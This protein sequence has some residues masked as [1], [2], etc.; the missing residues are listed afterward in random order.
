M[1]PKIRFLIFHRRGGRR[2]ER[3]QHDG[4]YTLLRGD[5]RLALRE[6]LRVG[7]HVSLRF[8]VRDFRRDGV[9]R[10][11]RGDEQKNRTRR[12]EQV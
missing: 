11:N 6:R 8:G 5:V 3:A 4:F 1:L 12:S 10:T 7:H 9:Q 2:R